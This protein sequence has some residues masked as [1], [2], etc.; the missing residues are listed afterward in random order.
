MSND[1][2]NGLACTEFEALLAD[3]LDNA[4]A[5]DKRL[6]FEAHGNTCPVCG[7]L[8]AEAKEGMLLVQ[9]LEEVEPP[10]NLMHNI[11]AAT[12]MTQSGTKP[13][14]D[15]A[16]AGWLQRVLGRGLRPSLAGLTRSRFAMSFAMAFFSLSITLTVLG[17]S[18]SDVAT[19]VA[20][21]SLLRKNV[22]MGFTRI[23]AKVT[24]YYENLRL[25][26]EV[27]ARVREMKKN[28]PPASGTGNDNKQQNRKSAPDDS[29]RPQP[30]ENYSREV[31]GKIVATTAT[32][33]EG[34]QI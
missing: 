11:L 22:V 10:K 33:H 27:Q 25:V 19:M 12:S 24:S 3:A 5:A 21:P 23:E 15:P 26:Y 18:A 4:L 8:W 31:D 17:V 6:E 7:P 28:T 1:F 9:G 29:G 16:K 30:K 13:V 34:A 20:H 14:A 32:R 2:Q